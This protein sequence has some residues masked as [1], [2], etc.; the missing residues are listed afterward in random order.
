MIGS[1]AM[2]FSSVSVVLS[3]LTI[4]FFKPIKMEN[5]GLCNIN[6]ACALENKIEKEEEEEKMEKT[7]ISVEG[8]MCKMCKAHVEKACMG[9]SGTVSAMANLEEKNVVVE[10]SANR[11]AL[12]A[13][14]KEAGYEAK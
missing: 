9:V 13:A 12:V 3:S 14:I 1:I 4:N 2:S 7:V 10:G 11:D 6:G 5:K 8:M